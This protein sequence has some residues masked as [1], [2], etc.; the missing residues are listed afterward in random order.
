MPRHKDRFDIG[1][2]HGFAR[3]GNESGGRSPRQRGPRE[4]G[5]ERGGRL[6]EH[7][8]LRLVLLQFIAS[9]PAHGYELIK[10]IE[11]K[12][13]GAY[14]PS[15]GVIYPTLTLLEELGYVSVATDA[16]S[17]KLYSITATG[18]THL[19]EQQATLNDMQQR[20][21]GRMKH[22]GD[23]PSSIL[24]GMENLKLALRLRL[25]QGEVN[26]ETAHSIAALLDHA[27]QQIEQL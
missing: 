20:F 24:R 12:T 8:R 21:A 26:A 14:S 5:A 27:A 25:Q 22:R 2:M 18:Q 11:D 7:G 10:A 23:L 17:R 1:R 9:K 15:P 4:L 6:F 16:S 13:G 19:S 3:S